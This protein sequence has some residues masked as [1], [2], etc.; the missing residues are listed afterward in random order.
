MRVLILQ[1]MNVS[2]LSDAVKVR[3]I[4][5][6]NDKKTGDEEVYEFY[7]N[8]YN[9]NGG[10][11]VPTSAA[12]QCTPGRKLDIGVKANTR[13]GGAAWII[14]D[15]EPIDGIMVGRDLEDAAKAVFLDT[16][17]G[18]DKG[19]A[20]GNAVT[21]AVALTGHYINA[22]GVEAF[23]EKYGTEPVKDFAEMLYAIS[24]GLRHGDLHEESK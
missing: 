15:C 11:D 8:E 24:F 1:R 23:E 2:Q 9:R 12:V 5:D 17:D 4:E 18:R 16:P 6:V 3:F 20:S 21:N 10:P 22:L 14:K 13:K 7:I 19:M